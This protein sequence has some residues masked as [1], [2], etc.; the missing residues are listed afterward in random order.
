MAKFGKQL[1]RPTDRRWK[2][3]QPVTLNA[4]LLFDNGTEI[5]CAI[6]NVSPSGALLVV[7]SIL[8]IP[9]SFELRV[10][11][12]ATHRVE[13]VRRSPNRLGVKFV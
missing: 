7:P 5:R 3:R 9:N 1:R 6:R 12:G 11:D 13:V 10:D 4:T 2:P 8:G